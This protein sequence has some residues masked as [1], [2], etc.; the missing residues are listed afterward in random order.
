MHRRDRA[1][2]AVG[3][4]LAVS[5]VTVGLVGGVH[6]NRAAE[7]ERAAGH[8]EARAAVVQLIAEGE[9]VRAELG[10]RIVEGRRAAAAAAVDGGTADADTADGGTA[11]GG[12]ADSGT[13]DAETAD[14]G[15]ADGTGVLQ[16][17]N[18]TLSTAEAHHVAPGPE[19]PDATAT[20]E[21]I[22]MA[23]AAAEDWVGEL[24]WMSDELARNIREVERARVKRR[25]VRRRGT[26]A[27][28]DYPTPVR[29]IDRGRGLRRVEHDGRPVGAG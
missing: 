7:A 1:L 14:A 29:R 13:A 6:E 21:S 24:R 20:I 15:E 28:R 27:A 25:S 8:E 17:L 26:C 2:L 4:V 12:T 5:L 10:A 19:V 9:A 22:T 3:A 11:D 16:A 23:R 18:E